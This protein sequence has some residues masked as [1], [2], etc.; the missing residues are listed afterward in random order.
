MNIYYLNHGRMEDNIGYF[1]DEEE[2]GRAYD[3]KAKELYGE[4]ARL[5]FP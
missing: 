3:A 4:Q 1:N 2:A 5:N